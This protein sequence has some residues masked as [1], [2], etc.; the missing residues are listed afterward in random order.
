VATHPAGAGKGAVDATYPVMP[1]CR[2]Q[3]PGLRPAVSERPSA[4]VHACRCRGLPS[5]CLS[6]PGSPSLGFIYRRSRPRI[7]T[8]FTCDKRSA[9]LSG[10]AA[11]RVDNSGSAFMHRAQTVSPQVKSMLRTEP[12]PPDPQDFPAARTGSASFCTSNPH[13]CTQPIGKRSPNEPG[14]AAAAMAAALGGQGPR[15]RRDVIGG[16]LAVFQRVTLSGP[17]L[18]GRA[19]SQQIGGCHARRQRPCG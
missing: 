6:A 16:D 9:Y 10:F 11:W 14:R 13:G 17:M 8:G 4:P 15:R 3:A 12:R 19:G 7:T 2:Q 1:D 18:G 5:P